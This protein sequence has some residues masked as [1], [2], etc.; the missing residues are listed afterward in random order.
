MYVYIY[1]HTHIHNMSGFYR[2]SNWGYS[3]ISWETS[4]IQTINDGPWFF[5]DPSV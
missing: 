1:I 2:D 5:T 4:E 3:W